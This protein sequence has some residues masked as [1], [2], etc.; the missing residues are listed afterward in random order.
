VNNMP[1]TP[2]ILVAALLLTAG[3]SQE[4][5]QAQGGFKRPPTPVEATSVSIREVTD[6]FTTVGTIEA[7]EAV[8]ITSEIDGIVEAIPFREGSPIEQGALIARLDDDQLR[9]ETQRARALHEQA[10]A[11][12][13]RVK[14]IVD[15]GAGAPQDLDDATAALKVAEANLALAETYLAKTRVTAPFT[16]LTGKREISPGAF[17]RAG[18]AI[19]S[20]TRIDRLRVAFAVPERLLGALHLG[21]QVNVTTTAFPDLKI[22]G[23]IDIIEPQLDPMTR[24]ASVIAVVEN[25]DGMLR[26]GMSATVE[27]VLSARGRAMTVPSEAVFVEGGQTFVYLIKADSTVARTAVQLGT[28]LSDV[29]EV[30]E[31][32]AEGQQLVR[33]GHQKLFE[34]ARI[35]PMPGGGQEGGTGR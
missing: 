25:P 7:S 14:S 4:Q 13:Q 22:T 5:Q 26:P 9:A 11:T 6:R 8:T 17:L 32:L 33:A 24:N 29:V 2:V 34:G 30:T 28:R 20:L 18:T 21:D 3:C 16:G 10:Q 19:T 27:T 23:T 35:S 15:Q 12:W 1:K 31:G